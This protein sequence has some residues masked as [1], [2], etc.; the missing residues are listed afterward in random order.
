MHY[1]VKMATFSLEEDEA[2]ELFIT[3]EARNSSQDFV[4]L[5]GDPLDFQSP[6]KSLIGQEHGAKYLDISDDEFNILLSQGK[7]GEVNK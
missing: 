6:C 1:F 4:E 3:Q 7:F 2:P 5:L